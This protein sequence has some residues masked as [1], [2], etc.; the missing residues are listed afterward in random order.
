M[1]LRKI[2][3]E[4]IELGREVLA[5]SLDH[6]QPLY[7][8][9]VNIDW[10]SIEDAW[11]VHFSKR[12]G[13]LSK[14]PRLIAGLL[15]ISYMKDLSDEGV[16]EDFR[17]NPYYQFLC[18]EMYFTHKKPCHSSTLSKWRTTIGEKGMSA[19]FSETVKLGIKFGVITEESIKRV[20]FDTTVVEKNIKYPTD[21]ELLE[22][23]RSR[24]VDL[25][26][27]AGIELTHTYN[28]KGPKLYHHAARLLFRKKFQKLKDTVA[29]QKRI[30][31]A[32]VRKMS[33]T[34]DQVLSVVL[35]AEIKKLCTV[36]EK[37][38]L[39]AKGGKV[40]SIHEPDV[41]V[42]CKGKIRNPYEYGC[43]SSVAVTFKECFI[44]GM[45][46]F[47]GAPYD[48]HTL[49]PALQQ[50][51]ELTGVAPEEAYAD[52]GYK[53]HKHT[54]ATVFISGQTSGLTKQQKVDL[55]RRSAVEPIIGHMKSEGRL[56]RCPLKGI[57]GDQIHALLCAVAHNLKKII[58]EIG[59]NKKAEPIGFPERC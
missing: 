20:I 13:R 40:Y 38:L 30:V 50:V 11:S 4:Q 14:R 17:Q 45:K 24:M 22:R 35:K 46:A 55:K 58:K 48:G 23:A 29:E 2:F 52:A 7:K 32:M 15:M 21:H 41:H 57:T 33:K 25:A 51:E 16:V 42:I 36:V 8:L 37:L 18:G 31:T 6:K 27:K 47:P 10:N 49:T 53:G 59:R 54:G 12:M 19:L 39:A 3:G 43:K 44:V 28:R 34:V 26:D 9:A 5:K 56:R 1:G